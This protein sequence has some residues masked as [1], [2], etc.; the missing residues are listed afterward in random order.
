MNKDSELNIKTDTENETG[1]SRFSG[2]VAAAQPR[3]ISRRLKQLKHWVKASL[4]SHEK[5]TAELRVYRQNR[6]D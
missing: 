2:S 4:D 5:R 6:T 1:V 3:S